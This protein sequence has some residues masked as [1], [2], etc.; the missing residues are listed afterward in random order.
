MFVNVLGHLLARGSTTV[1]KRDCLTVGGRGDLLLLRECVGIH[2]CHNYTA[3][4]TAA[5]LSIVE[6]VDRVNEKVSLGDWMD[7]IV[8]LDA[9]QME[10]A[11]VGE[12]GAC[13]CGGDALGTDATACIVS[14]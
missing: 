14:D 2:A 7:T 10:D 4:N 3:I 5:H 12:D 1:L 6:L 11:V 9:G 8:T 13:L